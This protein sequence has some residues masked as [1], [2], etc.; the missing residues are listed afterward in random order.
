[1]ASNFE[2]SVDKKSKGFALKLVGDF[3]ATSAYELIYAIKKLPE[4]ILKI[5][6]HTDGLKD[7]SPFGLEVFHRNMSPLDG[8][9]RKLVFTGNKASHISLGESRL[10]SL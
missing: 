4:D 9:S 6:I 7:I 8:L 2:V 10:R 1:M 3:D 5:F